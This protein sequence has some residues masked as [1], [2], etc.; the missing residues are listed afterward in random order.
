ML[1]LWGRGGRRGAD[2]DGVGVVD[3]L[4]LA[5]RLTC[6]VGSQTDAFTDRVGRFARFELV[7]A[8]QQRSDDRESS[9]GDANRGVPIELT[10]LESDEVPS[11]EGFD[12]DPL[13]ILTVGDSVM[14]Q[15]GDALVEWALENPD[16]GVIDF[17]E[18]H[19]GCGT[20]RFGLKR[21]PDVEP[22]CRCG[23]RGLRCSGH[24]GRLSGM[25]R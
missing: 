24:D 18:A 10:A 25:D 5:R 1:L 14:A 4:D 19:V 20:V 21:V 13:R 7:P 11:V 2:R 17:D 9:D 15:I 3:L 16:A 8:T 22:P 23:C 6:P 12:S